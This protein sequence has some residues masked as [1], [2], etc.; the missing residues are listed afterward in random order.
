MSMRG[1]FSSKAGQGASR[2]MTALDELHALQ[3]AMTSASKILNDEV[4]EAE[5][6]LCKGT[7][8]FHKLGGATAIFLRAVLGFERQVIEAASARLA[9][10]EEAAAESQ[11]R[12]IRAPTQRDSIYP[13][14]SQYALCHAESQLMAAVV[15]VLNESLTESL[16]GFYKLRQAFNTL[17]DI[18]EA[19][20]KYL[21]AN[22]KNGSSE[23]IEDVDFATITKDP[24]DLFIHSGKNLCFGLLQILLSM[25]PPAFSKILA[26]FSF[27]GDRES[28]LRMLWTATKFKDI[29]GGMASLLTL[30]F[31]SGAIALNDILPADALPMPRLKALLHEMRQLYPKSKLWLLEEA[32][33]FGTERNLEPAID[34]LADC[35]KSPLKQIEA[36]RL[37]EMSLDYMYLHE[38]QKCADSFIQCVG[39]NNWSHGLYY[40]IAG[41]CNVELYRDYQNSDPSKAAEYAAKADEYLHKVPNH[42]GKKRFMARQL[43]F[44]TFVLRKIAKWDHRAKT[45]GCSF[46]DAIGV[47][48]AEEMTYVWSGFIKKNDQQLRASL[49]RLAAWELNA[50]WNDE[51][52]DEKALL[53]ALKG[54]CLRFLKETDEAKAVL[55]QNVISYDLAK[56]KACEFPETWA[57]PVAH[58]ELAVCLWQEAGGEN[59]DKTI[60]KAC[61]EEISKVE[62]WESFDLDARIGMKV[63]TARGTLKQCG[64]VSV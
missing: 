28:G 27:R 11:R 63:A 59:G 10:S 43:P 25:I 26:I 14:G 62:K 40:Y 24:I 41:I 44:D 34:I 51:P 50:K 6:E 55:T 57:Q 30:V 20:K 19:E 39:M 47:S 7:S 9:E 23:S 21:A 1:W 18:N 8:P 58:Y 36:L 49:N 29:N 22:G 3:E 46:V 42:T 4:E 33:M 64:V 53:A 52:L 12:A 37:F 56:I 15:S 31:H 5:E 60:L 45:R 38:Y 61:G 13:A 2:S 16:R 32:R 35:E 17:H 54:T 48:P